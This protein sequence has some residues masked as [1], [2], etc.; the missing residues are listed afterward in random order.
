MTNLI[1]YLSNSNAVILFWFF[2]CEQIKIS[3]MNLKCQLNLMVFTCSA[4]YCDTSE[5]MFY[6]PYSFGSSSFYWITI[7][8]WWIFWTRIEFIHCTYFIPSSTWS[9]TISEL[10]SVELAISRQ[11]LFPGSRDRKQEKNENFFNIFKTFSRR[12]RPFRA[13]E[14]FFENFFSI[15][16]KFYIFCLKWPNSLI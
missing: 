16:S 4:I 12:I 8:Y 9:W 3:I 13:N 15:L 5:L 2:D 6:T 14:F 10:Y 7:F 11:I 1:N